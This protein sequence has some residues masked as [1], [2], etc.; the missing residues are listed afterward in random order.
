LAGKERKMKIG[1]LGAT[2]NF[3]KGL[4]Y[5]WCK[6]NEII[7]GS[8]DGPKAAGMADNYNLELR[9]F[10]IKSQIV[11][12]TNRDAIEHSEVVVLAIKFNH[13][14]PILVENRDSFDSKIVISPVV[15][16]VKRGFFQYDP[17][18]EGSAALTIRHILP[19]S[20]KV[21][22]AL[23]TVPA[24]GLINPY[25]RLEGD[26]VV[27]GDSEHAKKLVKGLVEEIESLRGLDGGSLEVSKLVEPIVPL[28]LNIK[29]SG[30]KKDLSIKFI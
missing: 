8:R 29:L 10:S 1:I 2:G 12:M 30:L 11:G 22:S 6:N 4:V 17:P 15:P 27:C 20:C 7:I 14:T 9:E 19:N 26:V 21:I 16:L 28:I 23:H 5:R 18:A 3:G 13:L 24:A 25:S